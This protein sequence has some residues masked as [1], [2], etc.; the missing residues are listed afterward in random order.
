MMEEIIYP[1]EPMDVDTVFAKF[2]RKTLSEYEISALSMATMVSNPD[3]PTA[4]IY[5]T[6]VS[7]A[8]CYIGEI[9]EFCLGVCRQLAVARKPNKRGSYPY[10]PSYR[11]EWGKYAV[12]D[13]MAM[14]FV[15]GAEV[16]G[17]LNAVMRCADMGVTYRNYA[18]LRDFVVALLK[19]AINDFRITLEWVMN[20]RKDT[21]LQAR[22][23][24]ITG[25]SYQSET[26]RDIMQD[27]K[28]I[29]SDESGNYAASTHITEDRWRYAAPGFGEDEL[30]RPEPAV[31][32][33]ARS[34]SE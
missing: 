18:K 5:L 10:M 34:L 25:E 8:D 16:E 33:P 19:I 12:S 2:S 28:G 4:G 7:A 31:Q 21:E 3:V 1:R 20:K 27:S 9:R 13:A 29:L 30:W 24:R 22:W 23:G 14:V 32:P 17:N 11:D 26:L 15:G 6:Y